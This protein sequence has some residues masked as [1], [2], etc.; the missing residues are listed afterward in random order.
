MGRERDCKHGG[1]QL[2]TCRGRTD[3]NVYAQPGSGTQPHFEALSDIKVEI[4]QTQG[5]TL[6]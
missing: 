4:V 6:G 5:M 1:R 2:A 3:L